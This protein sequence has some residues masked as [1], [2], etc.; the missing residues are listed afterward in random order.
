MGN[1][2]SLS[3]ALSTVTPEMP[4]TISS[5][6]ECLLDA[7]RLIL[8]GVGAA[9]DCMAAIVERGLDA[10]LRDAVALGKPLLGICIGMHLLQ[11]RSDENGGVACLGMLEGTARRLDANPDAGAKVPHMGWNRVAQRIEHPLWAG[12]AQNAWFY[13]LHSYAVTPRHQRSVAGSAH[14]GQRFCAAQRQDNV[15]GVQF[16][17]EKS[18]PAGLRLLQNFCHWQP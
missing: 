18:G 2:H 1:L 14:H 13:F 17:P 12:I 4:V 6:S 10:T 11:E 3:K 5:D 7:Q 8:P 15:F 9:R 16:H